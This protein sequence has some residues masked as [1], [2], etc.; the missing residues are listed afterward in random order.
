[1][2]IFNNKA[3]QQFVDLI[4]AIISILLLTIAIILN[5]F[6]HELF[7]VIHGN[8]SRN[9]GFNLTYF[10]PLTFLS[11][12]ISFIVNFRVFWNW[13][14]RTDLKKKV[15]SLILASPILIL[16]VFT[17]LRFTVFLE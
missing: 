15:L 13:N 6:R 16:F 9:F 2:T 7:G 17:L 5:V 4:L 11:L 14:K 12:I 1:M 10:I 3:N 8:A